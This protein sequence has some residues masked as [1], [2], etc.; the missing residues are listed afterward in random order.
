MKPSFAATVRADLESQVHDNYRRSWTYWPRVVAKALVT[1][2]IHVVLVFRISSLLYQNVLTRPLAFVLRGL[3]IVWG[4]TEIHPSARIGPGLCLMHSQSVVIGPGVVI[5]ANARIAHGV[6][7]G[8]D[9]GRGAAEGTSGYPTVGD[10][11]MFAAFSAVLGPVTIGDHAVV[12]AQ[13][14][15]MRDVPSYALVMGSPARKVRMLDEPLEGAA[16]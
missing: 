9:A 2:A 8:A 15:V 3:T 4:G 10:D 11:V 1:P 13:S 7:I 5:G 6:G 16:P 12:G 14:L